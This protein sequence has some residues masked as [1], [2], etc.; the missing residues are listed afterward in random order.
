MDK[1]RFNQTRKKR[2]NTND[3]DGQVRVASAKSGQVEWE[4]TIEE[5]T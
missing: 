3:T 1:G 4:E 2:R 5:A